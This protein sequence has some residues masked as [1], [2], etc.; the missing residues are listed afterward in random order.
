MLVSAPLSEDLTMNRAIL[1]NLVPTDEDVVDLEI[2]VAV[3]L[4]YATYQ[5]IFDLSK[6]GIFIDE[7]DNMCMFV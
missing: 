5:E 4:R 7:N 6:Y 2:H 3:L 1:P